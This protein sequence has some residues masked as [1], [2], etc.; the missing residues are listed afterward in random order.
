[1]QAFYL[2]GISR[3]GYAQSGLAGLGFAEV[4]VGPRGTDALVISVP[5]AFKQNNNSE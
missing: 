4:G 2:R 1:M 5:H 3:E